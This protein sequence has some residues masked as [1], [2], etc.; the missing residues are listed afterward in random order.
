MSATP[1]L[2]TTT[3]PF[4]LPPGYEQGKSVDCGFVTAPQRHRQAN[5]PTL[6]LAVV[7]F[8]S[9][10]AP[11]DP[12]PIF[13]L[14][15]G[16]GVQ[17]R[18]TVAAFNG[19]S[20]GFIGTHDMVLFDQRG[21][22]LSQPA[23]DCP[24][25]FQQQLQDYTQMQS[26]ADDTDHFVTA[27][28]RCRDR[29]VQQGDDLTVYNSVESAADVNDIRLA[30]G[31]IRV[32]LL[33]I[34]YG[35]RLALTVMRDFPS[36]VHGVVLDSTS[37]VQIDHYSQRP[38]NYERA[39][40]LLFATCDADGSCANSFPSLPADFTQDVAMLNAKP[41]TVT[42]ADTTGAPH[43]LVITGD[44]LVANLFF[45]LYY[46]DALQYLPALIAQLKQGGTALLVQLLHETFF[47]PLYFST[48]MMQAVSCNEN[49]PF[50]SYA[51]M[52]V[53]TQGVTREIR[54]PMVATLRGQ[55][56]LCAQWPHQRGDPREHQAV[57]S[58]IATLVLASANDPV[59]PPSYG[60]L[61][62]Q[63]LSRAQ[64]VEV[65]GIGHSVVMQGYVCARTMLDAFYTDPTEPP[66]TACTARLG[67][68]FVPARG[69]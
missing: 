55:F 59:T 2:D 21:V 45:W 61:A 49:V 5:G 69:A 12:T 8:R 34:S 57:A 46:V 36:V 11:A 42:V 67:M 48:G 3:C 18:Q 19:R 56:D 39:L 58:D 14:S 28:L 54:D 47:Q 23:I 29:L 15:G 9:P 1:H 7:R 35:T 32:D 27:G 64:Y 26:I 50:E 6:R 65:P 25:I 16:P 66:P 17:N 30:L 40:K 13:Y 62:A 24:E 38:A 4:D 44:R 20:L 53:E 22:G 51:G 10:Y 68:S 52:V 60:Q 37:P 63:T 43:Q 33:G 31:Y 41:M